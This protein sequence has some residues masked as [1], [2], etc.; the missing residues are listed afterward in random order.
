MS[1]NYYGIREPFTHVSIARGR[2]AHVVHIEINAAEAGELRC[3]GN[4]LAAVL[5]AFTGPTVIATRGY[6]GMVRADDS[7]PDSLQLVSEY[8]DLT[9]LGEGRRG[10]A[11]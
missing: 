11:P 3:I 1:T 5:L 9:T 2:T 8:G 7:L 4:E 10:V 6:S